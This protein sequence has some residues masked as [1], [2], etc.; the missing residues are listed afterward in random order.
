MNYLLRAGSNLHCL[1]KCSGG[2]SNFAQ[3]GANVARLRK[4]PARPIMWQSGMRQKPITQL[5]TRSPKWDPIH[6]AHHGTSSISTFVNRG[7]PA[8]SADSCTHSCRNRTLACRRT[9]S[10]RTFSTEVSSD[11]FT[12]GRL[13]E[14]MILLRDLL[15]FFLF[16]WLY[17]SVWG[18][19]L[20]YSLHI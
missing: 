17:F 15:L 14:V 16:V 2:S 5:S 3:D 13:Q 7:M 11:N 9:R 4:V 6:T 18:S 19:F 1:H 10:S 8:F 20:C 12:I